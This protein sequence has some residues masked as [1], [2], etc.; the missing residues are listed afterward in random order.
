MFK[1]LSTDEIA[2][3]ELV[4]EIASNSFLRT[5]STRSQRTDTRLTYFPIPWYSL[6]LRFPTLL[7]EYCLFTIVSDA[8]TNENAT[9]GREREGKNELFW[10]ENL[11]CT[12]ATI[13]VDAHC[14]MYIADADAQIHISPK[15][16]IFHILVYRCVVNIV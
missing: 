2:A 15:S 10:N 13:L 9:R 3:Q 7:L 4:S 11:D 12:T 6:L 16:S 1:S 5:H 14:T 8:G